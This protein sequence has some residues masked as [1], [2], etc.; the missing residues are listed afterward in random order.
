MSLTRPRSRRRAPL[1]GHTIVISGLALSS[2]CALLASSSYDRTIKLWAFKSR[3]LLASFDV[4]SP[5]ALVLSPDS[6]Q[7]AY[8]LMN[9]GNIYICNIPAGI[10]ASIG[11]A[12]ESQSSTS[13]SKRSRHPDL[14]NSD[15]TRR[16]MR[17]KPVITSVVSPIP[18]P[19]PTRDPHTF[20]PFLRKLLPSSSRMDATHTDKPRNLLD[21]PA[22]SPLPRPPIQPDENSQPIPAPPTSQSSAINTSATLKSSLHRL[23]T[24]RP[25]QTDHASPAIVDVPLAPGKLRYATAGA[26]GDD[27]DLIRDEDYVSPPPSPN[28][29]SRARIV[30][31]GQHGSGRFCFCF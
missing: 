5:H 22:T 6:R 29:G 16:P 18:R 10:L 27:D 1:K 17:R 19:L 20:L 4:E 21:F 24:W 15:A 3:Q 8:T 7:L 25:L 28:L 2:D 9:N 14:L 11:L 31:A 12:E 23:P 26:P 30:N 13:K